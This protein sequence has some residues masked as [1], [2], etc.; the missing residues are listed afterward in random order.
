MAKNQNQNISL[1]AENVVLLKAYRTE[2]VQ[3]FSD[4][5]AAKEELKLIV[6]AAADK[7]GI[8]KNVINKWFTLA[9]K[10]KTAEFLEH[11][12]IMETLSE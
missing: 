2:T 10:S 1:T 12:A 4:I 8:P 7:T 9:Y 5:D 6:E 11:A 3:Y